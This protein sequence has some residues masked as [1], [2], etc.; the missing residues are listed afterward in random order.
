M[1]SYLES[2]VKKWIGNNLVLVILVHVL[3]K[4]KQLLFTVK[5]RIVVSWHRR[6]ACQFWLSGQGHPQCF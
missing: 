3:S 5:H 4:Q 1:I 2:S 6:T